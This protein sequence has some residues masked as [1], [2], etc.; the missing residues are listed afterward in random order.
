MAKR[1]KAGLVLEKRNGR[2][3]PA[4]AFDAEILDG[5][6]EGDQLD[7]TKR[8]VRSTDQHRLYWAVLSAVVKATGRWPTAEHLHEA[9]K[10]DLGFVTV[11]LNL[12]GKPYIATDST[13]FDEM[14]QPEFQNYFDQALARIAEVTG[15]DPL[16]LLPP[17]PKKRGITPSDIPEHEAA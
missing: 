10:L 12:I 3:V 1:A 11:R 16:A 13:G 5:L 9:L 14:T 6:A 8:T 2:I 7:A 15:I 4:S 17:R